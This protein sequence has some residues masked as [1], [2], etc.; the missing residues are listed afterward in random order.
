METGRVGGKFST[1][2]R[3]CNYSACPS[4]M[5]LITTS[6]AVICCLNFTPRF[7]RLAGIWMLG[8]PIRPVLEGILS[9]ATTCWRVIVLEIGISKLLSYSWIL[10]G[11]WGFESAWFWFFCIF[12]FQCS[13][14]CLSYSLTVIWI[15]P[16]WLLFLFC[17]NHPAPFCWIR[18]LN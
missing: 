17:Y 16:N 4:P 5:P 6:E 15:T 1:F 18:N 10:E 2:I 3:I 13:C 14:F 9:A 7:P 12:L 11:R 8:V